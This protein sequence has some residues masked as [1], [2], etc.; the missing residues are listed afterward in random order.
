MRG[1]RFSVGAREPRLQHTRRSRP[2]R[3]PAFDGRGGGLRC[4]PGEPGRRR[5]LRERRTGRRRTEDHRARDAA[6]HRHRR[7][8]EPAVDDPRRALAPHRGARVRQHLGLRPPQPAEPAR[9]ALSRG[10]DRARGARRPHASRPD[11]RPG[12]L[13]HLP[14]PVGPR[15]AGRHRGPHERRP[16]GRGARRGVVRAGARCLRDRLSPARRACRALPRGGGGR[17]PAPPPGTDHLRGAPLPPPRRDLPAA[18]G[19]RAAS[20][21][22]AR[23]PRPPD[24]P[25]HRGAGRHVE[26]VRHAGGDPRAEPRPGRALPGHRPRPGHAHA[27]ALRLGDPDAAGVLGGR[28]GRRL[29]GGPGQ[30]GAP[31]AGGPLGVAPGLPRLRR[32]VPRGRHRPLRHRRAPARAAARDG[33]LRGRHPAPP[34]DGR[35]PARAPRYRQ[36]YA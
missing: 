18:P 28:A 6:P 25:D 23:R 36:I 27:L 3:Q 20:A 17:G 19:A 8:P 32:D 12:E 7:R 13:Q 33:A 10:L 16:A 2:A 11:R 5:R 26:L 22:H 24:A 4:G 15:E 35:E 14:P 1:R 30:G 31:P 29:G 34:P 9:G 21:P